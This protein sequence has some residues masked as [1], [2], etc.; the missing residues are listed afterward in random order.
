MKCSRAVEQTMKQILFLDLFQIF[1]TGS[2]DYVNTK[3]T[4]KYIRQ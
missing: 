4:L 3:I 2:T 1:I